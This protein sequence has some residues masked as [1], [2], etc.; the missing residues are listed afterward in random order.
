MKMLLVALT[1]ISSSLVQAVTLSHFTIQRMGGGQLE[2]VIS[3]SDEGLRI[4]LKSCRYQTM[5][6]GL[7]APIRGERTIAETK[8][9]LRGRTLILADMSPANQVG[10]AGSWSHLSYVIAGQT[11]TYEVKFP[12]ILINGTISGILEN[13]ENQARELCK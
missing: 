4:G 9:I 2:A 3:E 13:L 8:L 7:E 11:E 10:E 6:E 1:L 5:P 12:M